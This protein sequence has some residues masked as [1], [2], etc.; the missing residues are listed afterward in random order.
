M[1]KTLEQS[2]QEVLEEE[3]LAAIVR[4]EKFE[5]ERIAAELASAEAGGGGS[6]PFR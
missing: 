6:S 4:Q 5:L 3:E 1:G 2:M